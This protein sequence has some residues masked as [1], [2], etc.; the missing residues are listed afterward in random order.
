M[1]ENDFESFNVS[2]VDYYSKVALNGY[3][4]V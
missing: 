3:M 4:L 2:L 1:P